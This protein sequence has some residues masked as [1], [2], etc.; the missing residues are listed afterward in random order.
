[1]TA[2]GGP[3]DDMKGS[4]GDLRGPMSLGPRGSRGAPRRSLGVKES[5]GYISC[6]SHTSQVNHALAHVPRP[7]T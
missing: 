5:A 6:I 7:L 1:M 4:S 2:I 3:S